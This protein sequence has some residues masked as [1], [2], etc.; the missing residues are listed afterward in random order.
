MAAVHGHVKL[1]RLILVSVLSCC[2]CVG[3]DVQTSK[4]YLHNLCVVAA[5]GDE[6]YTLTV[7]T[8]QKLWVTKDKAEQLQRVADSFRLTR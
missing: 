5:R 3:C 7:L 6:L 8:P 4:L 1:G 2:C